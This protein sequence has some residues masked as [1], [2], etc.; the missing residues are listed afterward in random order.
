MNMCLDQE[1]GYC[2][3]DEEVV[4]SSGKMLILDA[5]LKELKK[6]GHK[7]SHRISY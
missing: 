7:V 2:K 5:M 4:K 6:T 1:T 3:I